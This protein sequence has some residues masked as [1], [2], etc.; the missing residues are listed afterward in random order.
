HLVRTI[1]GEY[2]FGL[3]PVMSGEGRTQLCRLGIG[4]KPQGIDRGGSHCFQRERRRTERAFVCVELHQVGNARLL[5]GHV[6]RKLTRDLAPER[7]HRGV[8]VEV[9]WRLMPSEDRFR[10]LGSPCDTPSPQA[11]ELPKC[12]STASRAAI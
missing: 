9:E 4:I 2:L 11:A 5:T 10:Q 3:Y 12:A 6:G 7:V 1:A 8:R